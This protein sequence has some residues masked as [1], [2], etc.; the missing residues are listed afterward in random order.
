MRQRI[1][2]IHVTHALLKPAIHVLQRTLATHVQHAIRAT[3]VLRKTRAVHVT[4]AT[5]VLP[6]PTSTP[7][8]LVIKEPAC[9]ALF[10]IVALVTQTACVHAKPLAAPDTVTIRGGEFL[11]GSN[12]AEREYAY[13]IDEAAY[14]H[15]RTRIGKWYDS[16]RDRITTTTDSYNITVTPITNAQYK[17]FLDS[18]THPAPDVDAATW[19]SYGLVHPFERTR[20]HAWN[21]N[22]PPPNRENHPVVLV[23]YE[24]A[25]AY[26]VW[27]SS[28][29]KENWRLPTEAEWEKAVRGTKGNIFPWGN[30]FD[31]AKLNSHDDGPFDTVAVGERSSPGPYGLLDG[32]GQ[33]FEWV[34]TPNAKSAW[35]KGGSWDDSGCGVCRPAARHSRN[36]TLR[37]ILIGFRL[38]KIQ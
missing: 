1:R 29:L 26:T 19:K 34:L 21:N 7:M 32:A 24:D 12:Q 10:L 5:R 18:T 33:V 37:H 22:Q 6:K 36:K 35:V 27:L 15:S 31:S 8:S 23:S 38:V 20:R 13:L 4:L 28:T 17:L 25:N 16:E 11:M 30:T 2:A 9:R 14:G 3:L